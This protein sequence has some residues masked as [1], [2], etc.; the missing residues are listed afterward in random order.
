M[1]L[2]WT[3]RPQLIPAVAGC[4]TVLLTQVAAVHGTDEHLH[5]APFDIHDAAMAKGY[6]FFD[7]NNNG[8]KDC[9]ER[10]IRDVSVSNGLE[11][12]HTNAHGYRH[13][14]VECS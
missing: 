1:N 3:V 14:H 4:C 5:P 7:I 13:S 12:V 11:V 2:K 6:V 8:V 9:F 10:G